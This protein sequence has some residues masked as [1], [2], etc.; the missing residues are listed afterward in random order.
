LKKRI[1]VLFSC[2]FFS[3]TY[4]ADT[5]FFSSSTIENDHVRSIC[6]KVLETAFNRLNI[7]LAVNNMPA[8]RSLIMSNSGKIDGEV[9]RIAGIEVKF[10]NLSKVAVSCFSHD[11]YLYVRAG[12]DFNVSGWGSIPRDYV[13]GYRKGVQYIEQ[14]A[15]KHDISLYPLVNLK[16]VFGLLKAG[17]IDLMVSTK[18]LFQID[19]DVKKSENI[20]MLEPAIEHH[21]FYSYLHKKNQHILP[22]LN[23]V[24]VSMKLSG[25]IKLIQLKQQA[26]LS[27]RIF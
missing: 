3:P 22:K 25:E 21:E 18:Q 24:L 27:K 23:Q 7:N 15:Q 14:A 20:I 2:V 6:V 19:A 26:L 16:Q 11:V 8:G 9:A 5:L 17:R 1:L 12:K 13:L 10:P 4:A